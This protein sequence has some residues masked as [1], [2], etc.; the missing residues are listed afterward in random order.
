MDSEKVNSLVKDIL[1]KKELSNLKPDFVLEKLVPVLCSNKKIMLK[2]EKS[3]YD[4][5]RRSKEH[6]EILKKVRAELRSVYG[7]FIPENYN[8]RHKLLDELRRDKSL[9]NHEKILALHKSSKERLPIYPLIYKKIFEHTR[10]PSKIL[11]LACGLN[12]LSYPFLGCKPEY[13]ACD[14]SDKDL[15][16]VQEYF[17]IMNIKGKAVQVN[18]LKDDVSELSKG[19]DVVFLFKALDSFESVRWNASEDLLKSLKAS[20]VVVSFATKSIGGKKDIKKERRSWFEKM[21]KRN[22]WEFSEFEFPGELFYIIR[23]K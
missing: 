8:K 3:D 6:E 17:K 1:S 10:I 16:F 2:L 9:E 23:L 15:E 22:K 7:V 13:V 12:P 20:F 14:L 4:K 18:L 11:D 5:F 21:I 19:V